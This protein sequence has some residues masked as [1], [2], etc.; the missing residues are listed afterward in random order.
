M[1][2]VVSVCRSGERRYDSSP[3]SDRYNYSSSLV[4]SYL[5]PPPESRWRRTSSDSALYQKLT[6]SQQQQ[7]PAHQPAAV[8]DNQSPSEGGSPEY[9]SQLEDV[10][11]PRALLQSLLQETVKEEPGVIVNGGGSS[12]YHSGSSSPVSPL[13]TTHQ[14]FQPPPPLQQQHP[15][16]QH[17]NLEEKFEKFRLD[18]PPPSGTRFPDNLQH[19]PGTPT[20]GH[21]LPIITTYLFT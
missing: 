8:Y 12:H 15:S 16:Q 5:S 6:G 17:N 3:Y 7:S 21:S 10:K 4:T 9:C 18:C 13:Y 1:S 14:S 19:N 2:I 20:T 11:P